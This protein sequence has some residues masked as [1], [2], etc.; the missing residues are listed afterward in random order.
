[1]N[2][3]QYT[4]RTETGDILFSKKQVKV[5]PQLLYKFYNQTTYE[6]TYSQDCII[7]VSELL[8]FYVSLSKNKKIKLNLPGTLSGQSPEDRDLS[9]WIFEWLKTPSQISEVADFMVSFHADKF[10]NLVS[11]HLGLHMMTMEP[12][13]FALAYCSKDDL[14]DNELIVL[15]DNID[16]LL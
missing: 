15:E 11:V 1:M 8:T 9:S 7:K 6:T 14:E 4:I 12:R 10:L 2:I 16:W 3:L 13:E 5:I